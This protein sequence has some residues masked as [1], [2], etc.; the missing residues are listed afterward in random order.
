M[1]NSSV[2]PLWLV[3][4]TSLLG[5]MPAGS[6]R[7][8]SETTWPTLHRD[9][10]RSGYTGEVLEGPFGRKWFRDFHDE[11]IASRVEAIVAEGLCFVPTFAGHVYALDVRDGRTMWRF[12]T[13]G[14]IGHSPCYDQGRLYFGADEGPGEGHL[15]CLDP[16][17]GTLV[18]KTDTGAGIWTSPACDGRRVYYGDRA[19]VF[20]ALDA[21]SGRP[22]WRFKTGYMIL[23]PASLTRDGQIVFASEDMHVYCLDPSGR[24]QWKSRRLPGLSLR[25]HAPTIWRGLAVVRTNPA[26]G[27]H[28]VMGRNG[29]MLEA[30]QRAIPLSPE[31]EVLLDRWGD[32]L[33]TPTPQ[34]RHAEYEAVTR[35]L[36][37]NPHDQTFFAWDLADG[38]EPWIA[39]VLYTCGLHN[40]ATP[41]TFNP[42]TGELYTFYRT[43]MTH[44]LRGI[45]RY[46]ALGRMD[47][48]TGRIVWSWPQAGHEGWHD[49]PMIGDETQAL[50]MMGPVLI[51]NHQGELKGLR[52]DTARTVPIWSGRDTYGGIFGP[53]ALP[54]GKDIWQ[55]AREM[56]AEGYLTGMP[57]EWHG[58]DRSIAAV[59][60]GRLFWVVG[61]Q[62]VCL[63]G[64]QVPR[65]DTGG[66][67]PPDLIRDRRRFVIGGNMTEPRG[68]FDATVPRPTVTEAEAEAL[69]RQVRPRHTP[70]PQEPHAQALQRRLDAAIGELIDGGPWAPFIVEL[71]IVR[72]EAYFRRTAETMGI[73]A[74]AIP[75]LSGGDRARDYL[76][77]LLQDGMPM[78]RPLFEADGRHREFY[79]YGPGMRAFARRPVQYEAG[80]EDVYGLWAAVYY[81]DLKAAGAE[82]MDAVERACARFLAQPVTFDH[83][84]DRQDAAEH[85]NAQIAG[86]IGYLRLA[87]TYD[88]GE[89]VAGARRR[90]APLLAERLY[91]E[92][93]DSR[94][95]RHSDLGQGNMRHYVKVPRYLRLVPE[96]SEWLGQRMTESLRAHV[97]G[98][99]DELPLWYQA[100]GERMIGGE[101]Y[102]SPPNLS[103]GLFMAMADGLGASPERLLGRLDQPWCHADL[104]YIEK[105]SALLRRRELE[106]PPGHGIP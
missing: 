31:D 41:P 18:W 85:L 40:P 5:T 64:P 36:R 73:V 103:R 67:E 19:G 38:T 97:E 58:P 11:M 90:L 54:G 91:H 71:G 105:L 8:L 104:Y 33:V 94:L 17:R 13:A 83:D 15:Y 84:D 14:P 23:T 92:Q 59:A 37:E 43:A 47:R 61:S 50:S 78:T 62:V 3:I 66:R 88:R 4:L 52:L 82:Q 93:A 81:A 25:D 65:S 27:F 57:N 99:A 28:T 22:L 89:H 63:A 12:A 72:E 77:G 48:G 10:Q 75:H 70:P 96:L 32:Y 69:C 95:L 51:S 76:R 42:T 9:Y 60:G 39:P 106:N 87:D 26:D 6:G 1:Q 45:R 21:E 74:L 7:A 102:V 35:Y 2:I 55:Q 79:D 29:E 24:L 80:I 44:Y 46:S 98:L 53:A 20:H 30:V 49:F 56:A 101:N 68:T 16:R 100:W 86:L 34:R